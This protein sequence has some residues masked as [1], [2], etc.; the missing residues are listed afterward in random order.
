MVRYVP[1]CWFWTSVWKSR[2]SNLFHQVWVKNHTLIKSKLGGYYYMTLD[3]TN[4]VEIKVYKQCCSF[5]LL[6]FRQINT[7]IRN[8][9]VDN[10]CSTA[11]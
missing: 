4:A 10:L 6:C 8:Y 7:V 11:S 3:Y 9:P 2:A 5:A 1:I